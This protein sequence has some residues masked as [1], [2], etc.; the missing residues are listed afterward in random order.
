[1]AQ[2]LGFTRDTLLLSVVGRWPEQVA[3]KVPN[4]TSM[5]V[6]GSD[7]TPVGD[8]ANTGDPDAPLKNG[9]TDAGSSGS[10]AAKPD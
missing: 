4:R 2:A 9:A 8:G 7:L 5:R 10:G 6:D 1:M 3:V